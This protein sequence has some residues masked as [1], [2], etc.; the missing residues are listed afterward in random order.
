VAIE[1]A[2]DSADTPPQAYGERDD[3]CGCTIAHRTFGVPSVRRQVLFL[4][5]SESG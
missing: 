1:T 3:Y 4:A 2:F 5:A